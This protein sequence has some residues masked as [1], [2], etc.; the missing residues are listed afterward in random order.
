MITSFTRSSKLRSPAW[1]MELDAPISYNLYP[2][3]IP[4]TD[5][6]SQSLSRDARTLVKCALTFVPT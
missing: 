1:C 4:F 5:H 2:I 3:H 6:T